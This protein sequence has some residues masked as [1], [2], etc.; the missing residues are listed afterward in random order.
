M[1]WSHEY[2]EQMK[3]KVRSVLVRKPNAS[4]YELAKVLGIDKNVA[5]RLKN[6]V[7]K[8]N[9]KRI[10]MQEVKRE[11]G[12][13]EAEYEQLALE[14]WQIITQD[15][16]RVKTKEKID[17]EPVEVEKD[18]FI[19]TK[20]KLKAIKN[21]IEIKEKMFSIKFDSGLFRRKIGEL[22]LGRQLSQEEQDLI[23]K[24][25]ALDYGN[26]EPKP[27]TTGGGNEPRGTKTA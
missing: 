15:Y 4:K 23:K 6:Q 7:I 2:R 25:I 19:E 8:E 16:R 3:E 21:I 12:K 26:Q 9:T 20:D 27:N 13:M 14:C 24:A 11:V 10:S 1:K 22:K 5:L 18:V 17:G